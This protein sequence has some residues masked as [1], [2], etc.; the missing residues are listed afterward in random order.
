MRQQIQ[1]HN[2]LVKLKEVA[3]IAEILSIKNDSR[4]TSVLL[5]ALNKENLL[6]KLNLVLVSLCK[7]GVHILP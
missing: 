6:F 3:T 7:V 4:L 2:V 1:T 5:L